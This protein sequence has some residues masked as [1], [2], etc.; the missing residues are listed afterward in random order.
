M[1]LAEVCVLGRHH[2]LRDF[3][4]INHHC[5][6][7]LGEVDECRL[8]SVF[9]CFVQEQ[10]NWVNVGSLLSCLLRRFGYRNYASE[11]RD[12]VLAYSYLLVLVKPLR[13]EK[14]VDFMVE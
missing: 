14:V 1:L 3:N 4:I 9:G 11:E 5:R 13:D 2:G 6:L 10:N 8:K 7:I 12:S